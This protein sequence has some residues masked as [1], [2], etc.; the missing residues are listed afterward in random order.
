MSLTSR[1]AALFRRD[2]LSRDLDD[3]LRFHLE[4]RARDNRAAGMSAAEARR[5]ARR[6]FGNPA[7]IKERTRAVDL[8]GW[9]E[10]AAADVRFGAR[11]LARS[12]GFTAVAVLTLA[13][14]IGANT[15]IWSVADAVLLQPLPY[16]PGGEVVV[17]GEDKSCCKFAPLSPADVRDYQ[18]EQPDERAQGDQ[19]AQRAQSDHR[20]PR[21]QSSPGANRVFATISASMGGSF[22]LNRAGGEPLFLLGNQV[23]ANYFDVFGVPA[24]LGRTIE[25]AVDRPGAACA[26]VISYAAW[27]RDFGADPHAAGRTV[28]IN[29]RP[30][31]LVGVMPQRFS[32][33]SRAEIW[34]AAPFA[35]PV[36]ES[37]TAGA[38]LSRR[39]LHY[40]R[41]VA[42][43]RPGVT[44]EAAQAA[45]TT[46]SRRIARDH[47]EAETGKTAVVRTLRH[48]LV[49]EAAPALWMLLGAVGLTLVI[50]CSNLAGLLLARAT[51][52]ECEIALR[53]ALGAGRLRL[54]RQLL[55]EV[56]LLAA[57]G[58][59]AG[60]LLAIGGVRLFAA[61][62]P[63]R[64]PRIAELRI[65][66]EA[67]LFTAALSL[68]AGTFAG[69]APALHAMRLAAGTAL[70]QGRG[71]RG[72][73]QRLRRVLVV[74]EIAMSLALLIG[75]G[76]LIRSFANLLAVDPGFHP[77][78]VLSTDL[79]LPPGRY[80][81][82]SQTAAFVERL[83][84]RAGGLPGVTGAGVIDA[85]PFGNGDSNGDI[86]IADRPPQ[87][88]GDALN[89][90]KKI[91]GGDY[92]RTMR[93]PMLAGRPF[94]DRDTAEGAPVA[95]VNRTL[96]RTVWPGED[97]VGKR[98]SWDGG[99]TWLTVVGV[100]GDVH[101]FSLDEA[102]M[103]DTYRPFRQ[104]PINAFTLVLRRSADP[105]GLARQL[106]Q[107]VAALDS[108]QPIGDTALMA[109]RVED[110]LAPQRI[111]M[112]LIC[113][114]AVLA[115]VLASLG[116]YG[117]IAYSVERRASEI[118]VRIALG[119]RRG[120]VL[121][122]VLRGSLLTAALG[123]AG[124]AAASLLLGRWLGTLL[125]GVQGR[126]PAVYAAACATLL[127]V[128][129]LASFLPARRAAAIDPVV[130]LRRE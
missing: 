47:P 40:L 100:V 108:R 4:M 119:A 7:L 41:P 75:A 17:L 59:G 54:V 57:L 1:L 110:S 51:A 20:E 16:R 105:L 58:G 31:T 128:A 106:R 45:V 22:V 112:L 61:L 67:L 129:L 50:G 124:G 12:P 33:L 30:C 52:R 99:K 15:T 83:L 126:D 85:V 53:S 35:L 130:T 117:L 55:S 120:Q 60:L 90:E 127:A 123:L 103:L 32:Y 88:P 26:A 73:G 114:L 38:V 109:D 91:T 92:F 89:A 27:R 11:L 39:D 13:L 36:P 101:L 118:G 14:G 96:A 8:V 77:D 76:L 125:F 68:V 80:Q 28:Q 42:R 72:G 43:L 34:V 102:P 107:E 94:D 65:R 93:I 84:A 121:A 56:W 63:D 64:L 104:V 116:V 78:G 62:G 19:P 6:R 97:A 49:H 95:I 29:D 98:L 66:P 5:D 113:S 10:D 37:D 79:P 69:L 3:E 115:L 2:R 74:A 70:Q 18:K 48:Y 111:L 82:A 24:L 25:P 44:L 81:T 21:G 122:L 87:R 71:V 86:R 46:I 9:L 23:A